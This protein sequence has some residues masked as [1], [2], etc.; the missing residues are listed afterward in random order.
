ML[1]TELSEPLHAYQ[2][3]QQISFASVLLHEYKTCVKI[4]TKLFSITLEYDI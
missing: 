3:G 2:W 1:S 4:L